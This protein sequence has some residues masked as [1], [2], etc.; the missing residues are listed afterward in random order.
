LSISPAQG[1]CLEP[2]KFIDSDHEWIRDCVSRLGVSILSVKE[3]AVLLFR[4]VRDQIQYHPWPGLTEN[5]YLASYVLAQRC[6]F[7]T[8]KAILLGALGRA[9]GV[10][11]ALVFSDLRDHTLPPDFVKALGTNVMHYHGLNA[12]YLNDDWMVVDASHSP[13]ITARKG[14]RPV[15]FDGNS[16]AKIRS[17]TLSGEPHAEYLKFHGIFQDLPFEQMLQVFVNAY[18][19]TDI[20]ALERLGF[21][22]SSQSSARFLEAVKK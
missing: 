20:Q 7:C 5:E 18:Q 17:T 8:Q 22:W 2:T 1:I 19:N 9:A 6:G 13:D 12:F 15:E 16:D 11:T 4:F 14:Y 3:K 21:Q 10:P